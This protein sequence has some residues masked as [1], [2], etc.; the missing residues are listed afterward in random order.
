MDRQ[1]E[2]EALT[3]PFCPALRPL[4]AAAQR[5]AGVGG[6]SQGKFLSSSQKLQFCKKGMNG[7]VLLRPHPLPPS[8]PGSWSHRC[9]SAGKTP[10]EDTLCSSILHGPRAR[11]GSKGIGKEG[12]WAKDDCRTINL[13]SE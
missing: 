11:L 4:A 9:T 2:E 3:P 13:L 1:L 7:V 12:W 8:G 5:W 10:P 6:V